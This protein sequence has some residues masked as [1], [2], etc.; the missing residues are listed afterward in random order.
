MSADA[1]SGLRFVHVPSH[2]R[3]IVPPLPC[4]ACDEPI[5]AG[6]DCWIVPGHGTYHAHCYELPP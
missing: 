1:V 4:E 5:V 6:Q 3:D 2:S